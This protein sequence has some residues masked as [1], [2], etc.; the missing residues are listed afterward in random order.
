MTTR[1][2]CLLMSYSAIKD[3]LDKGVDIAIDL[4]ISVLDIALA[5]LLLFLS[6]GPQMSR[7]ALGLMREGLTNSEVRRLLLMQAGRGLKTT[8]GKEENSQN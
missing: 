7:D 1:R 6:L 3:A 8:T 5:I 2:E 4:A